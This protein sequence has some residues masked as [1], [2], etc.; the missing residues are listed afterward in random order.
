MGTLCAILVLAAPPAPGQLKL[1]A[2]GLTALGFDAARGAFFSEHLAQQ[3]KLAGAQVVTNREIATLLGMERQRQLLGCAETGSSCVAEIAA[4]LGADGLLL[5][6]LGT[7]GARAQINLKVIGAANGQTLAA[8]SEN[9]G[10]DEAILE[11]LT[12]A[13]P[14]LAN[15]AAVKLSRALHP[16]LRPAPVARRWALIPLGAGVVLAGTG[17][18]LMVAASSNYRALESGSPRTETEGRAVQSAGRTEQAIGVAALCVA[19]AALVAA[20]GLLLFGGS[21]EPT[22]ALIDGSGSPQ[23]GATLWRVP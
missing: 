1:A 12:R 6:D 20:A 10:S 3:V 21:S 13:A 14:F 19:S 8:F 7:V 18:G 15:Q 23:G 11:A 9:V 2:P 16:E 22:A 4:A 5:G 17:A